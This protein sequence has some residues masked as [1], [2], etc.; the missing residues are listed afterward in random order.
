MTDSDY[1]EELHRV[2]RLVRARYRLRVVLTGVLVFMGGALLLL[3]LSAALLEQF[4]FGPTA[5]LLVRLGFYLLLGGLLLRFIVL[6]LARRL[7]DADI[8]LYI[9]THEPSLQAALLSAVEYDV[10]TLG[11]PSPGLIRRLLRQAVERARTVEDGRRIERRP[12]KWLPPALTG[13]VAALVLL[14]VFGPP[15]I[16]S[17]LRVLLMPWSNA[18]A[19]VP[20][21]VMVE[22]GNAVVPRG[23]DIRIVAR[24]RGFESDEVLFHISRDSSDDQTWET[25]RMGEGPD[26]SS[27]A[28]QLF[29]IDQPARY[30]VEANGIRSPVFRLDVRDLPYTRTLD[31][32]FRF[33]AYTG[34][35]MQRIENG[36]DVAA[37]RGTRV[38]VRVTPTLPSPGGQLVIEGKPPIPLAVGDSG[39]LQ[40][41]FTLQGDGFYHIELMGTDSALI[42]ASLDYA[43]EALGDQPPMVQILRPGRDTRVTSLEE[44]FIEARGE[45][46]Y[47]VQRLE[48]VYSV[49]GGPERTVELHGQNT[50]R[51]KEVSAG[52]TLF[53]EEHELEPGDVV[54]YYARAFDANPYG[55]PGT[56]ATDIYFLQVRPFDREYREAEQ[57]GMPG[58]QQGDS[59][60]GLSEQQREIVSATFK[61]RRDQATTSPTQFAEN[62]AT[63]TLA[64]GRL[65]QQV[66]T[67]VRRMVQRG[68]SSGDST[69]AK[70]SATLP[71][72]VEAM[73]EAEQEL[74]QRDPAEALPPEQRALQH[75][76]RAEAAYRE[77]QVSQQQGGGGGGG[78]PPSSAEDLADLFELENDRVQNQYEGVQRGREEQARQEMDEV[79]ER[80]KELASRQ[81]QEN[82]RMLR[83]AEKMRQPGGGASGGSNSQRR[84]AQEV[85]SLTRRLERLS[86]EQPSP[87]LQQSMRRLQEAADAM[88]RSAAQP[89]QSGGQ[90]ARALDRIE[91]ARRLLEEGNA[92]R[93][94][95]NLQQ[96]AE[97]ARRLAQEQRE[98]ARQAASLK[99]G[100]APARRRLE[101]TKDRMAGEVRELENQL[102]RDA[103]DARTDQRE[104]ARRIQE[105]VNE[106]RD[107]RVRE[108]IEYSKGLLGSPE[109]SRQFEES[110]TANLDELGRQLSEA[111]GAVG[112]DS[113]ART[114]RALDRARALA[115]GLE[116]LAERA[117]Q[118]GQ[119]Q[120]PEG[121]GQQQEGQQPGGQQ[122]GGQQPGGEARGQQAG[123]QPGGR[124]AGQP[125]GAP[126]SGGTP[127]EMEGNDPA[128]DAQPGSAQ[129]RMGGNDPRQLGR[130]LRERRVDAERL[131]RELEQEGVDVS[132]LD[133]IMSRMRAVEG[134]GLGSDR[135]ALEILK[136]QVIEGLKEFEF[137]LR[138]QLAGDDD[139]RPRSGRQGEV[140][141]EFRELVDKYYE[142]LSE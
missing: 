109:S 130:E 93:V 56:A 107:R 51:L 34:L 136:S 5:V 116:S 91:E 38:T 18:D 102:E 37:L 95:Q 118:Q 67:L 64:Q 140:A 78:S 3:L 23:G 135:E 88:R 41:T 49:N 112:E 28:A 61:A 66:E 108:K 121:E 85:D 138:R 25:T 126:R 42:R 98:V 123:E 105:A 1:R 104:A 100:D 21:A 11:D 71:L 128:G 26:S 99:P 77:V 52:H 65:R 69:F 137:A 58:G 132:Q 33:P 103:R 60:E 27:H 8:A 82:E 74:G 12:L 4:N 124:P 106:L 29:D 131:R 76:Q 2:I 96:S 79:M 117:E 115:Q 68:V 55:G 32:E 70:I 22:P 94:R 7:S 19:V 62:L 73:R 6:P 111:A 129:G 50:R 110:I 14:A 57:G 127:Q 97:R 35:P 92:S 80:L 53:L 125:D 17:A 13:V 119:A 89:S 30:F 141:P 133:R 75:L 87:E 114:A 45:D 43:I 15:L 48:L 47:G 31:L 16:R 86:R 72:A 84:L 20:Y 10:A 46:D 44:V 83:E 40:G 113:G 142:S 54:S 139:R 63:I 81:Q 120:R 134:R 122:P 101:Q 36:G 9:E 90:G 39:V 24:L 59:P